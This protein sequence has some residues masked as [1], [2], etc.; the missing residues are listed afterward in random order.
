[1]AGMLA[2]KKNRSV[3]NVDNPMD[4]DGFYKYISGKRRRKALR[5]KEKREWRKEIF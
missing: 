3:R 2:S 4:S 1:M 5:T